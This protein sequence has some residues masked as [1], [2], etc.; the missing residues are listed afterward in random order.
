M[1]INDFLYSQDEK[2]L[3]GALQAEVSDITIYIEDTA[4]GMR[5][6]YKKLLEKNSPIYQLTI[7]YL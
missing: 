1:N 2:S 4:E 7:L 3:I 6:F 5:N